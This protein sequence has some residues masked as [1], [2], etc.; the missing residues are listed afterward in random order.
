MLRPENIDVVI[1]CGGLG[2]RLRNVIHDRP[3][4]M[5][6]IHEKP[7]LDILISFI[8][9]YGFTRFILCTGFQGNIIQKYYESR[10]TPFTIVFSEEHE[11]MGTAGAIKNAEPF[12]KS[13]IFLTTN[14]DSLCRLSIPNFLNFHYTK[15]AFASIAL[16]SKETSIDCGV[17][18]LN[19][20]GLVAGFHEKKDE[21]MNCLVNAGMYF[22]QREALS[23]IPANRNYSLEHDLFPHLIKSKD[24]YGFQT[25]AF[26]FDIG[27]PERYEMAKKYLA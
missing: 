22:F 15:K 21:T 7:F 6:E 10:K 12:I 27:T 24:V 16:I 14:G 25:E 17:V 20:N 1:L 19:K 13:N 5:A 3:K 8:S 26:L 9:G 11:A 18:H 2:S 4:P 23:F